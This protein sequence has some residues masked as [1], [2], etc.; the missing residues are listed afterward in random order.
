M[1]DIYIKVGEQFQKIGQLELGQ[2][3]EMPLEPLYSPTFLEFWKAYPQHRR[4]GK[5]AAWKAWQKIRGGSEVFGL[6][7]AALEGYKKSHAWTKDGG[8][9]IPL[10]T[11]WLNQRR[12]E[13]D[14]FRP[15]EKP[16]QS[17]SQ[18]PLCKGWEGEDCGVRV[19]GGGRCVLHQAM[20]DD[21]LTPQEEQF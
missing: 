7:G 18:T 19:V 3:Q 5:G 9:F 8:Q 10:P 16:A 6:I 13:D 12:W 2:S 11:T 20:A 4:T 14:A 21:A 17:T 1:T 15:P